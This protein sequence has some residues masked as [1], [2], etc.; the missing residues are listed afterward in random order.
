[1]LP[2]SLTLSIDYFC[3]SLNEQYYALCVHGGVPMGTH[4]CTCL[5]RSEV[6][7]WYHSLVA[8]YLG[9]WDSVSH[10]LTRSSLIQL[11]GWSAR[12]SICPSLPSQCW[13]YKL[14]PSCMGSGTWTWVFNLVWQGLSWVRPLSSPLTTTTRSFSGR[15]CWH[16]LILLAKSPASCS[17][18]PLQ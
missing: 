5:Q 3:P 14:V 17:Q 9:I 7:I 8:I 18:R 6:N 10:R 16:Q 2:Y 12:Y 4:V 15:Y 11:S 13:N 1:M